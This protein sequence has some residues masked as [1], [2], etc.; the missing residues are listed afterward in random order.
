[1]PANPRNKTK[2]N[3]PVST[4]P[5]S[6]STAKPSS[7]PIL[8][9]PPTVGTTVLPSS[10]FL[11]TCDPPTKQYIKFLDK[12]KSADKK[13]ILEDLDAT[14]LLIDGKAKDEILR[15]VE[16]WM[17]EVSVTFPRPSC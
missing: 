11:V 17:D 16:A 8:P 15:K 9:Q 10:G 1:M 2:Q 12:A 7:G 14:H 5:A 13:F 4:V 6:Q 3:Q